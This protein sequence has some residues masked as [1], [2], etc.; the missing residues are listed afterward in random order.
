MCALEGLGG[1]RSRLLHGGLCIVVAAA[2]LCILGL[3]RWG[4]LWGLGGGGV[5]GVYAVLL[6]GG[7]VVFPMAAIKLTPLPA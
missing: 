4:F 6:I 5:M 2:Q 1:I 7:A 3:L